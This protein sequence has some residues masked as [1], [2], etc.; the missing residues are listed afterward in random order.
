MDERQDWSS[1]INRHFLRAS[2]LLASSFSEEYLRLALL[3]ILFYEFVIHRVLLF[4]INFLFSMV[5]AYQ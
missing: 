1:L 3:N 2:D 4:L 5:R